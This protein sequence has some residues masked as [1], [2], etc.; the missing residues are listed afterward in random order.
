MK[1]STDLQAEGLEKYLETKL[2]PFRFKTQPDANA[3]AVATWML[4]LLCDRLTSAVMENSHLSGRPGNQA[5]DSLVCELE[6]KLAAFITA[7]SSQLEY[8]ILI[9]NLDSF[10]RIKEMKLAARNAGRWHE[11]LGYHLSQG[12]GPVL[13]KNSKFDFFFWIL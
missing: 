4:E 7:F 5:S 13:Q 9:N 3:S 1:R 8:N 2:Q 6:A 11:L 10:G 12:P